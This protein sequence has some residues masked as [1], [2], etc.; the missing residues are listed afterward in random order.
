M[1]YLEE[2]LRCYTSGCPLAS[3]LLLGV[4]AESV[5][6]NLWKIVGECLT[7]DRDKRKFR[8]LDGKYAIAPKHRWLTDK[9]AGL[10]REIQRQ[11]PE[12][13]YMTISTLY[14]LI[15][16]QRNDLGHPREESPTVDREMAFTTFRLFPTYIR[17]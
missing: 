15:R 6:L 12:N 2:A 17:Q 4:A 3:V 13:L 9:I 1:A 16:K 14:D 10:P 8:Q 5:F 11:L 7:T